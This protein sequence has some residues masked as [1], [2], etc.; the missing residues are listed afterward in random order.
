MLVRGGSRMRGQPGE[1][2]SRNVWV[3]SLRSTLTVLVVA[4]HSM[5]AY[6]GFARFNH[7]RYLD[8]TAPI[9]DSARWVFFDYAE[10]F[11]DVF[12]MSLMF[13]ISGLF[14]LPGLSR[15]GALAYLRGRARRLGLIFLLAV[16]LL[17]PLAY[18]PSYLQTGGSLGYLSY[19]FQSFPKDG[20]PPGPPWFLWLL[21]LFDAIAA[22][23]LPALKAISRSGAKV[24]ESWKERPGRAFLTILFVATL[25]YIPMIVHFGE[26][27]WIFFLTPPF[28]FQGSRVLLYFAWFLFGALAGARGLDGGLL[29]GEGRLAR[30][31]PLWVALCAVCYNLLWF[32]PGSPWF[33]LLHADTR[34]LLYVML[35]L[36][37]CCASCFACLGL[38]RA[39]ANR[40]FALMKSLSRSAYAIFVVHYPFV[41]WIQSCLLGVGLPAALKFAVTFSL[42][43][44]LSWLTALALR[45]LRSLAL[46][47]LPKRWPARRVGD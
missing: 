39:L 20:L 40:D 7:L 5:L 6:T 24:L 27:R 16:G 31:W 14:V 28:Y 3:D 9:V 36:L 15:S 19:W 21:L 45:V 33:G 25:A 23:S 37:S 38:Y 34:G 29:S 4:H 18:Y 30:R 22:I 44:G 46:E 10:N 42:S 41:T 43:L 17:M 11:N 8:S 26:H 13:F 12:F 1:S 47:A 2:S 32:A 35:W